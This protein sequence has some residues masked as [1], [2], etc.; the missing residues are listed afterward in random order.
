MLLA[1]YCL[2]PFSVDKYLAVLSL[3]MPRQAEDFGTVWPYFSIVHA[4]ALLIVVSLVLTGRFKAMTSF[5][6]FVAYCVVNSIAVF[7]LAIKLAFGGAIHWDYAL[8]FL[9][10]FSL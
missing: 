2:L 1:I 3:Q 7:F 4:L 6:T 8:E 10:L 9:R 5:P